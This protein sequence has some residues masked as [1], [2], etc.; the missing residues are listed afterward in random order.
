VRRVLLVEDDSTLL[1]LTADLL[2]TCGVE[3]VGVAS[4]AELRARASE[5]LACD[6]ALLD[7]NLGAG[8]PS[9]VDVFRWLRERG[10]AGRIVFLTGHARL[11]P[12]VAQAAAHGVEILDKPIAPATLIALAEAGR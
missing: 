7:V 5:A 2:E 10:F 8:E 11:Q 6:L 1:E 4:L 12:L 9:G 3:S